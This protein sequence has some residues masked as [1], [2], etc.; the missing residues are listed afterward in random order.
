MI[1]RVALASSVVVL[2]AALV[3]AS[4]GG[5]ASYT[6]EEVIKAFNAQGY[7]LAEVN[8]AGWTG[9]APLAPAPGTFL[10]PQPIDRAPF[11]VFVARND[12]QAEE[13]FVPFAKAGRGPDAF[14]LLKGNLVLSS[15]ASLTPEG[16][17]TAERMRIRAAMDSLEST[18]HESLLDRLEAFGA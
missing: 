5:N 13:F 17:T 4:Q 10:F 7:E 2:G 15:D 12:R 1:S 14:D 18:A 9:Y 16:L 6:R 8:G 11:Y 3:L